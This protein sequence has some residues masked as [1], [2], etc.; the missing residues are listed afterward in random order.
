MRKMVC[1]CALI[2]M[3]FLFQAAPAPGAE[4]HRKI[5]VPDSLSPGLTHL[6]DLADPEKQPSFQPDRIK[7]LLEGRPMCPS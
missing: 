6:L 7:K 1:C 2:I 4:P 3:T 5:Q